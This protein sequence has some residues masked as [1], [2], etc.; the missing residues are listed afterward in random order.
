[1]NTFSESWHR[2]RGV[3]VRLRPQVQ[4]HRQWFRGQLWFVVREPFNNEFFRLRASAHAFVQRLDGTRTVQEA[5][6]ETLA[7]DP[8]DAPGQQ[9]VIEL[10]ARLYAANLIFTD[11]PADTAALFQRHRKRRRQETISKLLGAMFARF[12]LW[13]PDDFLR[14]VLPV[15][16]PLFGR[17][18]AVVWMAVVLLGLKGVVENRGAVLAEA[19]RAL[20]PENL[21]WL[22][23]ATL[24]IKLLHEFGHGILCRKFGGEVHTFGV[25]L[26]VFTP[27]PYVDATSAWSFRERWQRVAVGA[28]G[29]IVEVFIAGWAAIFWAASGPGLLHTLAFNVMFSASVSTL[30]FNLNPLLRFDGYYMLMDGLHL[31]NLSQRSLGLIRHLAEKKLFGLRREKPPVLQLGEA[32]WLIGYGVAS[33][34]YRIVL[35]VSIILF[36]ATQFPVIGMFLAGVCVAGWVIAPIWRF[37]VYIATSPKLARVRPRACGVTLGTAAA[38]AFVLGVL[39]MPADLRAPGIVQAEEY[40]L[41]ATANAGFVEKVLATSGAEVKAGQPLLQLA[42][43]ELA[44][45]IRQVEAQLEEAAARQRQAVSKGGQNQRAI[46]SALVA[47]RLRQAD[48]ARRQRE[49]TVAAAHDGLWV[50]PRSADFLGR[51]F[52]RGTVL[53]EVVNPRKFTFIARIP[54]RDGLQLVSGGLSGARV[55]LLGQP[56]HPMEVVDLRIVQATAETD[57]AAR[58]RNEGEP[59]SAAPSPTFE[60]RSNLVPGADPPRLLHGQ[61]GVMRLSIPWEP[62][63]QQWSRRVRQMLQ[64]TTSRS[65]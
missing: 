37:I 29:M 14:R 5:W 1:M 43:P 31:P 60:L 9:D 17:L 12:P 8:E 61:T 26:M 15:V 18:G 49:L 32:R 54:T 20:T 23:L 6:E 42:D 24:G 21:L 64:K 50:A 28:G 59:T 57:E 7:N 41:V 11:L 35:S 62:L 55:R 19:G 36:V 63:L 40:T 39:P 47:L 52:P 51:W 22:Y 58:G 27:M 34:V 13:D 48:L 56:A 25:M 10:L 16:G 38:L 46:E 33:F 45:E 30:L 53:G 44:F 4:A 3:T 2:V 65:S